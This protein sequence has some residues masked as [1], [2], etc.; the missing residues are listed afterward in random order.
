MVTY[1]I[2]TISLLTKQ[3]HATM[4]E[5][6]FFLSEVPRLIVVL[7]LSPPPKTWP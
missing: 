4:I 1:D 2:A 7:E 5:V 6:H 3:M